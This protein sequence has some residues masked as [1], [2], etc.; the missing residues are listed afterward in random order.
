M[1][2]ITVHNTLKIGGTV[3]VCLIGIDHNKSV[4]TSGKSNVHLKFPYDADG[5]ELCFLY[6]PMNLTNTNLG[7][8]NQSYACLTLM[9]RLK[10]LLPADWADAI[11]PCIKYSDIGPYDGVL[12]AD[13]ADSMMEPKTVELFLLSLYEFCASGWHG[14][15]QKYCKQYQYYKNGNS[16][17]HYWDGDPTQKKDTWTRTTNCNSNNAQHFIGFGGNMMSGLHLATTTGVGMAPGFSIS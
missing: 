9:P 10:L 12:G 4:E 11:T 13:P 1:N 3:Y 16:G 14:Y 17:T 8:Y 6:L 5:K 7:G 15:E 2:E